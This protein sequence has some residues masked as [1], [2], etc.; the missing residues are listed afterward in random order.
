MP[1]SGSGVRSSKTIALTSAVAIALSSHCVVLVQGQADGNPHDWDRRRRCD[2]IDYSPPCGICEGYGGIPYGDANDQIHLTTCRPV[3][4]ASQVP[5]PVKPEWGT[6]FTSRGY[7]EVLI[8]P[9]T[10]P[11]CF[12]SFPSNSSI[13]K[14]CYRPDSGMQT[15]DAVDAKALRYDLNVKTVVGNV[16]STIIHQGAYMWIVN[17][18]PWYAAGV[19]QCICTE[20]HEGSDPTKPK[21]YPVAYNWTDQM[22]YIGREE[23]GIEYGPAGHTEV[24]EH[25]AFGPHHVWSAPETGAIRRMWQPFNGLEVFPPGKWNRT[26]DSSLFSDIPPS[27]CRKGGA[28]IRIKC[29][30]DGYPVKK[31]YEQSVPTKT[32][33]SRA[34]TLKPR[35]S[36]RGDTFEDMSSTLNRW[37][38]HR[39]EGNVKACEEFSASDLQ[40]LQGLLYI[41]RN[42]KLDDIYQAAEDNRRMRKNFV[43][44]QS[45][46]EDLRGL[47]EGHPSEATRRQLSAIARDG[48]CHEA[49]MWFVHHLTE[50]VKFIMTQDTTL[51]LPL[52]S[53]KLHTATCS[54]ILSS[55]GSDS[56]VEAVCAKYHEQVTCAS[57]HSNVVPPGH[58]F[59]KG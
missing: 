32:D 14:L 34:K 54:Q 15:Y 33:T 20:I 28:A 41:A 40:Q 30:D 7:N 4:N 10:D 8:G 44:M 24:L 48:H 42:E 16:T 29:G 43:D 46:W 50:E 47:I 17:H 3:L 35:S 59:L 19:H 31:E 55:N 12:N 38:L 53:P 56:A 6:S 13:G 11:F 27:L 1:G 39:H 23:I 18:L 5:H 36:Y 58:S 57:C 2:Q 25:W 22:F 26:V 37:L 52:L 49:V 45:D 51:K 9:K 21:M